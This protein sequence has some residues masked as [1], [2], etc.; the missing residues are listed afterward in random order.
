MS[1]IRSSYI[2]LKLRYESYGAYKDSR[3][4]YQDEETQQ[5]EAMLLRIKEKQQ[6]AQGVLVKAEEVLLQKTQIALQEQKNK[7]LLF[8]YQARIASVRLNEQFYQKGGRK[9]WR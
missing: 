7:I 9:L 1:A 5:L 4:K 8:R 2:T 3:N 6:Q